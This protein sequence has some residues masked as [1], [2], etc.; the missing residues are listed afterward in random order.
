M[1]RPWHSFAGIGMLSV[2]L[3]GCNDQSKRQSPQ[4]VSKADVKQPGAGKT[5]DSRSDDGDTLSAKHSRLLEVQALSPSK[6]A[7]P[8]SPP[9][10][11]LISA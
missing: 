4:A 7:S 1:I 5:G 3:A 11:P 2:L 9:F 6:L 8:P 10:S